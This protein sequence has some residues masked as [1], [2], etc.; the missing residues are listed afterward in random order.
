MSQAT[1]PNALVDRWCTTYNEDVARM[2]GDCYAPDCVV[3]PMGLR[4]IEGQ[5]MLLKVEQAVLRKAP[6]RRMRVERRHVCGNVA[7]VEAVLLDPDRGDDWTLPFVA[8]LTIVDGRIA[9]DRTYADWR[10]WPGL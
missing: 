2:V 3:H 6:R 7:C 10:H 5:D 4:A 9:I 8:V 1:D